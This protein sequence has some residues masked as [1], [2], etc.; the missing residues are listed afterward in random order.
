M[1][2]CTLV[3]CSDT[4]H[5]YVDQRVNFL[6]DH[7]FCLPF[8]AFTSDDQ[9]VLVHSMDKYTR[10]GMYAAIRWV[11]MVVNHHFK[12]QEKNEG[13]VFPNQIHALLCM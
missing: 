9:N 3:A 4:L 6:P 13:N 5:E 2:V 11:G 1:R 12:P 8:S 10:R 7:R